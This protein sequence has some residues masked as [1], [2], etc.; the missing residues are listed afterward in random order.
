VKNLIS[1]FNLKIKVFFYFFVI[2]PLNIF[3]IFPIF[4]I[5]KNFFFKTKDIKFVLFDG[6]K[7]G[8]MALCTEPFIKKLY[9]KRINKN[10]NFLFIIFFIKPIANHY[11]YQLI[12]NN[13]KKKNI[14]IFKNYLIW[15]N[16]CKIYKFITKKNILI[17]NIAR[18]IFHKINND[19]NMIIT[20]PDNDNLIGEKIIK[21][22][23]II[24]HNKWICITNRDGA[25]L[26]KTFKKIDSK[27][28]NYRDFDIITMK[29]AIEYF[30]SKDY[31]VV[32][33]GS[34]MSEKMNFKHEM[35]I[36]YPFSKFQSD[37]LDIYLSAKCCFYFGSGAGISNVPR[38]FRRPMFM[39]NQ[40]PFEG[41]FLHKNKL[42]TFKKLRD[43][44]TNKILSISEILNRKLFDIGTS[45]EFEKNNIENISN[46]ED[47]ILNLAKE[48]LFLHEN[49]YKILDQ[50]S[51]HKHKNMQAILQNHHS[52]KNL[53]WRNK[54]GKDFIS[55][56]NI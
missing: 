11:Y 4:F 37:F 36:D 1:K 10:H 25:Y 17:K 31:Y 44:K 24:K 28:H 6:H 56:L 43:K 33:I 23:G 34:L 26:K 5:L 8:H 21:K 55:N 7:I 32:R 46:N 19:N 52:F 51:D 53:Y 2:Y 48:A 12:T 50:I 27:Y 42:Q 29:K 13:L 9:E 15:L 45:N 16:L 54:I 38:L 20:I 49:D 40:A 39:I 30:I 22:L 35:F 47:E 14:I 41:V 18:R 3:F